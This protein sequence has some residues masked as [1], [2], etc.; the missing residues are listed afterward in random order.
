[1]VIK[2]RVTLR[3]C[4]C[5]IA[6]FLPCD[7]K[8]FFQR[9]PEYFCN[10][11]GQQ[12]R[13]VIIAPLNQAYRLARSAHQAAQ[14]LLVHAKAG[15][16]LFHPGVFAAAFFFPPL[17][18]LFVILTI[19]WIIRVILGI[20]V[21]QILMDCFSP[22]VFA[23][24]TLPGF[25]VFMF[26][27]SMLWSV[28]IHGGAVLAVADPF[29]LTM[30]GANAAAFAAGTQPP[31]I[32]ASGFTMF[33]F[34]GGGGATLPLV[35]MMIR[36]KEKG[37]STLGKLCL[38]ASIFEINEPVVFGVPLVMNPYMMIPY[39]LSTLIL[40]AGTYLLMLFNIIGRPV[41]N[42]PWTIPPLFSHYLVTGGN[43]PAVIWGGISLLIAGCIYY[44]FF[45][46]MERQRLAVEKRIG[47]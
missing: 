6:L 18:I 4:F 32:T 31:Y 45:K 8:Y 27:R 1:M 39:T 17:K 5:F 11:Q 43:I 16:Q 23:L 24:N 9:N 19:I 7:K 35:L 20:N 38:P 29:F 34:L 40:S 15:P 37:F 41:A 44:P 25:L 12:H 46:A 33:V 10:A 22:F 47:A 13:R 14:F 30:F 42:I 21:N 2:K 26:I 28:G 36:S 3:S